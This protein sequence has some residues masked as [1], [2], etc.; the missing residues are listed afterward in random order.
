M[1]F[2]KNLFGLMCKK[3]LICLCL[4]GFICTISL[5]QTIVLEKGNDEKMKFGSSQNEKI[6]LSAGIS[7]DGKVIYLMAG[8]D[9][10]Q[11]KKQKLTL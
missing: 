11:S 5:G 2:L 9:K 10:K 7:T 8:F 1:T 3:L 6:N 4:L